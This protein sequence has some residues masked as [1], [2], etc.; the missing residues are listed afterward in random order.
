MDSNINLQ[1]SDD[2]KE[3]KLNFKK[4]EIYFGLSAKDKFWT[5]Y[6]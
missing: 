6:K 2:E 5:L 1:Y 3:V 4:P